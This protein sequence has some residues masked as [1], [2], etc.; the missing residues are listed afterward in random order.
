MNLRIKSILF[1]ILISVFCQTQ[2]KDAQKSRV[3]RAE[4]SLNGT[5]SFKYFPTSEIGSD[6]LFFKD[7]YD[8]KNWSKI[9]VPGHWDLQ[10]FAE[11]SEGGI[12]PMVGLYRTTFRLSESMKGQQIFI[13]FEGVQYGYDFYV[14]GKYVAS[15]A[16]SYNRADFNI[17][18]KVNFSGDNTLSVKVSVRVKGYEFDNNDCWK[19]SGIYRGVSVFSTSNFHIDDYTVQT[20]LMGNNAEAN[21]D[22]AVRFQD[23]QKEGFSGVSL[24]AV[25]SSPEGKVIETR[26]VPVN[27]LDNK[28]SFIVKNPVLWTAETPSLYKL[29]LQ[30]ISDNNIIDRKI[31]HVGIRQVSIENVVLKLNGSPLKLRGVDHHDIVPE[32]GRTLTRKEI[33]DDLE[34]I[35]KANINF[36]R[37]SHYPPDPR[38]LDMCDSLGIYV[39]CEVPFGGGDSHLTDSSYQDILL[40]RAE[41][42]LWRDKNHPCVIVWSIGNENPLT[43]IT[44]VVGKY[45][46]KADP[47][48]PICYPQMGSYFKANYKSFPDFPDLYTPHYQGAGWIREFQKETTKPV[49][50]T[51]YAHAIGLSFGNLEDIWAELFRNSHFAGG[52]VWHFHDQGVTRKS[53]APVD[54]SKPTVFVWKD[55]VTYYDTRTINGTDGIVYSDRTPQTDYWQ[56]RKVYS[57]VRVVETKLPVVAGKQIL[58]FSVYNQYDFLNLSTLKGKWTLYQNR[59]VAGT[60]TLSVNCAPHDTVSQELPIVLPVSPETDVWHLQLEFQDKNKIMVCNHTIELQT[61]HGFNKVLEEILAEREKG[62]LNVEKKPEGSSVSYNGF[63]YDFQ[64]NDL[65]VKIMDN[66]EGSKP[67]AVGLY[68]HTGRALKI[69]D[70]TMKGEGEEMYWEPHLLPATQIEKLEETKNGGS[71]H[72]SANASFFRGEKFPGQR[73]VGSLDYLVSGNGVLTVN[74]RW[75]P[76]N[77]TGMFLEAGVSFMLPEQITDFI[78]L[79]D[80]PYPSHPDKYLLADYGAHYLKKGDLNF[81]GNRANVNVAVLTDSNGNGIAILGDHSN[82]SVEVLNNQV[83]LSHNAKLMGV[84]NKGSRAQEKLYGESMGEIYGTFK[85]I[86]LRA[87]QWPAKLVELLGVPDASLRPFQPFYHSYDFTW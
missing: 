24:K 23:T 37:T 11:P 29:E 32:T 45:V 73:L 16:S 75:K 54:R 65:S 48:R 60:G 13:R 34:M 50:L 5:W 79:G 71:F 22:V 84:G 85:I 43:P 49:I 63:Y 66:Q 80:G 83:I 1:L 7:G 41:A 58:K 86:P 15:Y 8:T 27:S 81:N 74:Y 10:G 26:V 78:W 39:M 40:K 42:T 56:V 67:L 19:L 69:S 28:V 44:E 9:K 18:D 35:Q 31:Q 4:I 38:M 51:E 70:M 52:A 64:N 17:T 77:A 82:I 3:Q 53:P 21:I 36:I 55:S 59:K 87:N 68:A 46:Q 76:E 72:L 62:Q 25:L 12:P 57:P 20:R 14:N 33:L 6:S 2:A 30:L 61:G 47:T